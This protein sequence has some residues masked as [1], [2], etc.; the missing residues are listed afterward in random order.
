MNIFNIYASISIYQTAEIRFHNLL[1]YMKII[2][3]PSVK[4][5]GGI[6]GV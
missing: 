5:E 6:G 4:G 3:L 2:F 1:F